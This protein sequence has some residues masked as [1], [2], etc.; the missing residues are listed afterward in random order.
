M[1]LSEREGVRRH[2][3]VARQ[4]VEKCREHDDALFVLFVDL[5]KAYDSVPRTA[6]WAVLEKY[7]IPPIMLSVIRSLHE[8]MLAEVRVGEA[9]TD[10]IEVNNGLRQGCP[11]AP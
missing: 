9:T 7:G 3:V 8:G 1:W 4:M 5:R 11:L 10:S 2:G 6:M